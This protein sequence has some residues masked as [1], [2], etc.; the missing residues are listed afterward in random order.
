LR[1]STAIIDGKPAYV[2]L[3]PQGGIRYYVSPS[4]GIDLNRYLDKVVAVRGP[5]S[6]RMEVRAQHITVRDLT[7]IEVNEPGYR[8]ARSERGIRR[9]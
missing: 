6:Y 2:L 5:S 7:V 9:S 1:R 4:P 3:S 8:D